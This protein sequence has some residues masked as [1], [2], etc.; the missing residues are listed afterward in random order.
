MVR[1]LSDALQSE[2][3][4]RLPPVW[5]FRYNVDRFDGAMAG[6]RHLIGLK[7]KWLGLIAKKKALVPKAP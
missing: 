1:T 2:R 4:A 5:G 6:I 7:I 3:A